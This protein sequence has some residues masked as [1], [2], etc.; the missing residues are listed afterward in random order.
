MQLSRSVRLYPELNVSRKHKPLVPQA[1][2]E[3]ATVAGGN[4]S[5]FSKMRSGIL[6]LDIDLEKTTK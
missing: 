4:M 1:A 6:R 2:L 3:N 5:G